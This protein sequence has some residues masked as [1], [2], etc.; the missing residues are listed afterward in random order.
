MK[1]RTILDLCSGSGAWSQPYVDAGYDV[2]RVDLPKDVRLL[3][4]PGR[5]HGI[6]AAPPC[7]V[8]ASSGARWNRTEDE[9][10]DALS[11]VDA[12]FRLVSVCRPEWWV[13]ENPVGKLRRWIGPP[14]CYFDPSDYGDAY[15][16]KTGLWGHFTQPFFVP[17][18]PSEGSRMHLNHGGGSSAARSVTP[19]GFAHAFFEANP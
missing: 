15:T 13:L 7:T 1:Y 11:I 4:Y 12:C 14:A 17:T 5:V 3:E 10:K 19:A 9:M 16:K 8:F 18:I 6:L 2:V